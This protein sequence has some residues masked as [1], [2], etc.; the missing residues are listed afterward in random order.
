MSRKEHLGRGRTAIALRAALLLGSA[1]AAPPAAAHEFWLAPSA[2]HAAAGDTVSVSAFVGTGFRGERRLYSPSRAAAFT[3]RAAR[4][5]DLTKVA[6]P[7]EPVLAR[8]VAP[9][10]GG[11]LVTYLS[12]FAAIALPGDEFDEYLAL[13]GL[14]GAL[15]AR[16]AGR[17]GNPEPGGES[18]VRDSIGLEPVRERYRRCAKAWVSGD[19]SVRALEPVG[20]PFEIVPLSTP[21][22]GASLALRV[23][24]DG[25]PLAGA[26]VR[27]WCAALDRDDRPT[28][29]AARD[30][31]GAAAEGRTGADGRVVLTTDKPGEWLVSVVHM[32]PS[33]DPG[34]ADWESYWA[35]LTFGR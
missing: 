23:D 12:E 3:L 29:A 11:A 26:L 8:F 4:T 28:D 10:R 14:D 33:R 32:I 5:L 21:G 22:R 13:E 7:G 2:Y 1:A 6:R 15:A 27:A 9:D 31:I 24:F 25:R 19:D 18:A 16:R 34:A 35:S 17:R 30:S 20:L